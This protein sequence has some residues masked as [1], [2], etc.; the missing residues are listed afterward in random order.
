MANRAFLYTTGARK[1]GLMDVI[2]F[3]PPSPV[4]KVTWQPGGA[5]SPDIGSGL[6][7]AR[8]FPSSVI[9]EQEVS[10]IPGNLFPK[11]D[12]KR[13]GKPSN[14][15]KLRLERELQTLIS[16]CLPS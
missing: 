16:R 8:Q 12:T 11:A 5:L 1:A 9:Q 6:S 3:S 14:C 10:S 15:Y 2:Q 13:F 4:L 7:W